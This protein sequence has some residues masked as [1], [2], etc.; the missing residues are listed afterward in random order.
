[1]TDWI[2]NLT[3]ALPEGET[4]PQGD[5]Y[6]DMIGIH[7]LLKNAAAEHGGRVIPTGQSSVIQRRLHV[8]VPD[9][10]AGRFKGLIN[11]IARTNHTECTEEAALPIQVL[12]IRLGSAAP[13]VL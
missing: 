4:V 8:T 1:M 7:L 10:K 12:N 2:V 9:N 3:I 11:R 13:H 6:R 5:D